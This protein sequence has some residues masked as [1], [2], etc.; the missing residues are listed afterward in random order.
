MRTTAIAVTDPALNATLTR[1]YQYSPDGNITNKSTE[2]GNYAYQYDALSRLTDAINPT[3]LAESYTYD[4]LGNRL[5]SAETSNPWNYNANNALLDSD[6][7]T[8]QYDSNGNMTQ[9]SDVVETL[10]FTFDIGNRLKSIMD[11]AAVTIATYNYD[12]FGRRLWREVDGVRTYFLYSDEG[13]IGEYDA[14]GTEIKTYGYTPNS[15]WSTDPLFQ[16]SAGVYTGITTIIWAPR[17]R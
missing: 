2:H 7:S 17:R 16:K 11:N 3:L 8:F 12:P 4:D 10:I 14:A 13:L 15:T 5:T 6:N 9:K 1:S